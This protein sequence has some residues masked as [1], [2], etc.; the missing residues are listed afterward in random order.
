MKKLTPYEFKDYIA[1]NN[2][3]DVVLDY[4]EQKWLDP[5][6]VTPDFLVSFPYMDVS[7]CPTQLI[8]SGPGKYICFHGIDY[9]QIEHGEDSKTRYLVHCKSAIPDCLPCERTYTLRTG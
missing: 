4:S 7:I 6:G 9:I 2:L 3:K 1:D 5:L 8:L